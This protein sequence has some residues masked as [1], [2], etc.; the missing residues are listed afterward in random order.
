M[1]AFPGE[2]RARLF[3]GIFAAVQESVRDESEE[4]E[5]LC[6]VREVHSGFGISPLL[7]WDVA[8][9]TLGWRQESGEDCHREIS[10]IW[11]FFVVCLGKISLKMHK[12]LHY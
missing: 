2:R 9:L 12:N 1:K 4:K 3:I 7:Q 11:L 10:N 8:A 5:G 6:L